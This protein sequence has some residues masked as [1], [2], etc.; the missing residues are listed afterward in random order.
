MPATGGQD[1]CTPV[2]E[3]SNIM[4]CEHC[5]KEI[6]ESSKFCPSCGKPPTI[7]SSSTPQEKRTRKLSDAEIQSGTPPLQSTQRVAPGQYVP[8]PA[9]GTPSVQPPV[10]GWYQPPVG[11]TPPSQPPGEPKRKFPR[12]LIMAVAGLLVVAVIVTAVIFLPRLFSSTT[13]SDEMIVGFPNRDGETDLYLL[14]RGEDEKDGIMIAKD[15]ID[16]YHSIG[17]YEDGMYVKG[18]RFGGFIPDSSDIFT[19]YVDDN[20]YIIQYMGVKDEELNLV[21]DPKYISATGIHADSKMFLLSEPRDT[22]VRCYAAPLGEEAERIVK[23]DSC[24]FSRDGSTIVFE[25]IHSDEYQLSLIKVDGS[26]EIPV[27]DRDE[28]PLSYEVSEDASHIAYV[29]MVDENQQLRFVEVSSET[30]IHIGNESV[31]VIDYGFSPKQDNLFY[32]I[33]NDD[34]ELQLF[35]P[36]SADPIAEDLFLYAGFDPSGEHL[37]YLIGD[38]RNEVIAYSYALDSGESTEIW[39][40]ETINYSIPESLSRVVFME[41]TDDQEVTIY[42]S[43][44]DGTDV[45]ELFEDD[46]YDINISYVPEKNKLYLQII[47]EDGKSLYVVSSDK[48]DGFYL[49]DEWADFD[50]LSL[51]NN[52]KI[53]AYAGVEDRG[54]DLTLYSIEVEDNADWVELDDDADRISNAVFLP[55]DRSVMYTAVTGNASDDMIIN[56]VEISGEESPVE[57]YDEAAIV[58]VRWGDLYLFR[59]LWFNSSLKESTSFCPGAPVIQAGDSREDRIVDQECYRIAMQEGDVATFKIYSV[60]SGNHFDSQLA[61]YDRYGNQLGYNDDGPSSVDSILTVSADE[62]GVYF[63]MV[64]GYIGGDAATYTLSVVE[65]SGDRELIAHGR[66]L[67][68][69]TTLGT[70]SAPGCITCHSL[71]SDV[72]LVG[73]SHFGVGGRAD[74]YQSGV[75]AEEYLRESLMNP[76]TYLVDG[77]ADGVMYQNYADELDQSDIDAL[78]AFLLTQ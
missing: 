21:L 12:W 17:V 46:A 2:I 71:S 58:D 23:A 22:T 14:E 28:R 74:E 48:A 6:K 78:V 62:R 25:D 34:G 49:L 60:G 50:L 64:Q 67:Y 45:I 43:N 69:R 40:G 27:L 36:S 7:T 3:E 65:G 37:I 13:N 63:L 29:E 10:G 26:D 76:D 24:F 4:L 39:D 35:T 44:F 77:F 31:A 51:S 54:D 16:A 73:P 70:S 52:E 61:F 56:Q 41:T 30:D 33:E 19:I 32:I 38:E 15:V 57:L 47:N 20:E 8:P 66:T 9:D 5:D 1:A 42:S 53:L 72:V 55:N 68:H 59:S 18:I 11:N 75:S